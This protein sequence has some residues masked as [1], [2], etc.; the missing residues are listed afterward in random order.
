MYRTGVRAN[1]FDRGFRYTDYMGVDYLTLP[2]RHRNESLWFRRVLA[3]LP[4]PG[5]PR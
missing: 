1:P 2:G 5:W 3:R 4:M